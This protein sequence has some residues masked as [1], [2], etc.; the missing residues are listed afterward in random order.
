MTWIIE[1][2]KTKKLL[3]IYAQRINAGEFIG[4]ATVYDPSPISQGGYFILED[5]PTGDYVVTNHPKRSWFAKIAKR[6]G[7][8]KVS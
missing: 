1:R 7:Q 8:L 5:L 2:C 4:M 6:D 3:K